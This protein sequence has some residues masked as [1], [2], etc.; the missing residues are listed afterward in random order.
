MSKTSTRGDSMEIVKF[1]CIN[2]KKVRGF[3]SEEH[4][5]KAVLI[6]SDEVTSIRSRTA[7]SRS[8]WECECKKFSSGFSLPKR[9][10]RKPRIPWCIRVAGF[11]FC[12][13]S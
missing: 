11:L 4:Q 7:S 6:I 10:T 12:Y 5:I 13:Q 1:G 9:N 8:I 2:G 3:V